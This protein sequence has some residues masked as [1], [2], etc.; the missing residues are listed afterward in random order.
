VCQAGCIIGAIIAASLGVRIS[1]PI[2]FFLMA[3]CFGIASNYLP[4]TRSREKYYLVLGFVLIS[5]V[6]VVGLVLTRP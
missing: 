2:W 3:S 6:A 4:P 1:W 5:I